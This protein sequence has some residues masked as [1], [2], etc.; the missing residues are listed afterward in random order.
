MELNKEGYR[1][2][3]KE[4]EKENKNLRELLNRAL[5]LLKSIDVA[6]WGD[7]LIEDFDKEILNR[8]KNNSYVLHKI[9]TNLLFPKHTIIGF[10]VKDNI[11][12]FHIG[13]MSPHEEKYYKQYIKKIKN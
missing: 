12:I 5:L 2:L 11:I 3:Y 4:K 6:L 8:R 9:K 1:N 13:P 7:N 10:Y